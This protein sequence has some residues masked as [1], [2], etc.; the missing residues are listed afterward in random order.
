LVK[1]LV[2]SQDVV[3]PKERVET[4]VVEF[5]KASGV[6]VSMEIVMDA[7]HLIPLEEPEVLYR[8]IRRF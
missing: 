6:E 5:L 7:K 2:G 4:E 3:E 8:E 1:V